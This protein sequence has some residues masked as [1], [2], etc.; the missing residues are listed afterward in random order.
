MPPPCHF[1]DSSGNCHHLPPRGICGSVSSGVAA[2]VQHANESRLCARNPPYGFKP[3]CGQPGAIAMLRRLRDPARCFYRSCAVVGA[4]GNLLGARYG[5]QI[6]SHDAVIRI[7]L[8]PDGRLAHSK[9]QAPHFHTPTW[10]ADIGE[11]TTWR[12]ITMEGYGYLDHYSRLWLAPPWGHGTHRNMSGIPQDPLLAVVCHTPGTTMGRC[13]LERLEQNFAHLES[14]SYLIN[15]E[16]LAELDARYFKSVQGQKTPST[17][18]SALAFARKMC[19]EVHLYG[20]GNGTCG[21]QCYHYYE[22]MPEAQTGRS[23]RFSGLADQQK[24][25][26]DKGATGGFHNF[27]A[28][29]LALMQMIREGAVIPHWGTC[30]PN[31]GGAPAIYLNTGARNYRAGKRGGRGRGRG[32]RRGLGTWNK[33]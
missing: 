11:R 10:I 3:L 28:Q 8:A 19:G 23:G 17:G 21:R 2:L 15:P 20:F 7:N 6:D 13:R 33:S 30:E 25:L 27:S 12:V 1:E 26:D 31:T 29:A 5:T 18:M 9:P 24:F 16:I 14:A 4:S 32:K 22:C